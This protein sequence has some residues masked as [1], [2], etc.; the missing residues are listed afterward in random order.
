VVSII[1]RLSPIYIWLGKW[2]TNTKLVIT[3]FLIISEYF[4]KIKLL[5]K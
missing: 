5:P 2:L 3:H 4:E 1:I